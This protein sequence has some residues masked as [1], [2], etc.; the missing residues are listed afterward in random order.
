MKEALREA[1]KGLGRTS[2]NPA[3]G[4]V[5]VRDGRIVA[6]AYHA[7]AGGDHAEA[8]AIKKLGGKAERDDILYVTLEPCT[9]T[10]RTPPC[11]EAILRSGIRTVVVGM[12]DPNPNVSGGG[13]ELLS[14]EGVRV[15]EGVLEEECR[16]INE[17]FVK[18]VTTG[19]PFVVA[20]SAMTLDGWTATATGHSS[21]VTGEISRRFV[22]RLRRGMDGI[23]VG[24]GT[25]L[26]D[27]PLLTVRRPA[28]REDRVPVRIVVDTR[29]RVPQHA[30][31]LD[32][33]EA[34]T[35]IVAGGD[36]TDMN[37]GEGVE[38]LPCPL[39]EGRIDLPA[40]LDLL[41]KRAIT[42]L[43]VE[44]GAALM[45]SMIREKLID[46]FYIFKAPKFLGGGDGV[47]MASGPGFTRMDDCLEL[48]DI[49]VRRFGEDVLITGYPDYSR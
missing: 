39:K 29:C 28:R 1:R 38:I 20:K 12:K 48:K 10:G 26:A 43:L 18:F 6:S 7:R 34:P 17:A 16:R 3:V 36:R 30:R 32:G 37:L 23:M 24:I 33:S 8:A 42:S 21:W 47:P 5:I 49:R 9:H 2:P 46:K 14:G 40:L 45:G 27:D 4:A 44:G 31:I 22:H 13:C 41:G 15:V 19:R 35:L 11:T 25:V